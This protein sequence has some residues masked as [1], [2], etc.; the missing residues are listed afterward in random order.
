[1]FA[2]C[3]YD[4]NTKSCTALENLSPFHHEFFRTVMEVETPILY[5][6]TLICQTRIYS[7]TIVNHLKKLSF[8]QKSQRIL[9]LGCG[10]GEIAKVLL[11][12]SLLESKIY[13]AID[14]EKYF[15]H[16]AHD[17]IQG[18]N[19]RF[20]CQNIFDFEETE[21]DI[22]LL[23]A[24]L[25]HLGDI[26]KVIPKLLQLVKKN[27]HILC[28]DAMPGQPAHLYPDIPIVTEIFQQI[29]YTHT[30]GKRNEKC[31]FDF[32]ENAPSFDLKVLSMRL[33]EILVTPSMKEDYVRLIFFTSELAK[34]LYTVYTDQKDLLRQLLF[35]FS[36]QGTATIS[37]WGTLI[38]QHI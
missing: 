18:E 4:H 23:I 8:W 35:W 24:V 37:G 21:F 5:A 9:D 14:I 19:F 6:A 12:S 3:S 7:E 32:K 30:F 22:I 36:S 11:D 29:S 1:M 27:G 38:V 15:I 20:S 28:F 2:P 34:R 31:L 13:T 16:R 26:S 25:Q 17:E 33:F 10:P